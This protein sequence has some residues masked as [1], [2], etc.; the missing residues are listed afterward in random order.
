MRGRI[1]VVIALLG[2]LALAGIAG[3]RTRWFGSGDAPV[4]DD[5]AVSNEDSV[6]ESD[7]SDTS[8]ETARADRTGEPT[9]ADSAPKAAVDEAQ[10]QPNQASIPLISAE[11]ASAL[12]REQLQERDCQRARL[13][14]KGDREASLEERDWHWLPP[15]RAE[16]ERQAL[17]AVVERL[18]AVCPTEI[19]GTEARRRH[20]QDN[21]DALAAAARAGNLLA[22]AR[23]EFKKP[24]AERDLDAIRALMLETLNSGDLQAI[25]E[26][27]WL[28]LGLP[29]SDPYFGHLVDPLG[30]W[31]LVACDLGADCGPGSRILDL[32]CATYSYGMTCGYDSLESAYRDTM[33]PHQWQR[34][35]QRRNEILNRLRNGQ[36]AGMFDPPPE[37]TG[38][39]GG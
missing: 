27:G 32:S 14:I 11:T 2:L 15:E 26:L 29:G 23:M 9:A 30:L 16:A 20:Q 18:R 19:V 6:P 1:V 28:E 38:S 33:Q 34:L 7:N 13:A 22:R 31:H 5:K 35:D 37:R 36:T 8:A 10:H 12:M 3:E 4:A 21:D 25:S 17:A 24:R 39:G